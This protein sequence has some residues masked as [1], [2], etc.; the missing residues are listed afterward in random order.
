MSKIIPVITLKQPWASWVMWGWKTIETRTHNKFKALAGVEELG[1]HA[2]LR[3]DNSG[4][5]LN[6]PYLSPEAVRESLNVPLGVILG[7]VNC[8]EGGVPLLWMHENKALV[9]CEKTLR[10]GLFFK[11]P[12][13][14]EEPL[15]AK[16]E[17]SIWY[18]DLETKQKVRKPEK[19]NLQLNLI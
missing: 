12:V 11:D 13:Q 18:Y 15:L 16:G 19:E 8:F 5:V 7:T 1:I 3:Y 4:L 9:E 6:N 10:Y 2:G 14:F 17:L